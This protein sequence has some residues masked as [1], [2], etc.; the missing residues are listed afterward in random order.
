MRIGGQSASLTRV[1]QHR[2]REGGLALAPDS[3]SARVKGDETDVY[4]HDPRPS[5][6]PDERALKHNVV[7]EDRD[8]KEKNM[9]GMTCG[10]TATLTICGRS[11]TSR[12]VPQRQKGGGQEARLF[13]PIRR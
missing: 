5:Q 10:A 9:T 11:T 13:Q 12:V 8:G 4:P 2:Q 1:P 3:D 7:P 6:N